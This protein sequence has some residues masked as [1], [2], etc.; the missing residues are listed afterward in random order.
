[1]F[2]GNWTIV[3]YWPW[4]TYT[5]AHF[6]HQT[7]RFSHISQAADYFFFISDFCLMLEKRAVW[8]RQEVI[9]S[10]QPRIFLG[11]GFTGA[12]IR[13][14]QKYEWLVHFFCILSPVLFFPQKF[15]ARP[16]MARPYKRPPV[17]YSA[18]FRP[19]FAV[20][21]PKFGQK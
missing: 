20:F 21:T 18:H 8:W 7:T 5:L 14:G 15:A 4:T 12:L 11:L 10:H 17:S 3:G 16:V 9:T 13:M 1:M 19:Y 2:K 6:R